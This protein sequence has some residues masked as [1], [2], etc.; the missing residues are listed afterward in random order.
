MLSFPGYAEL[1]VCIYVFV[2]HVSN[3]KSVIYANTSAE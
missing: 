1:I 2:L 3:I